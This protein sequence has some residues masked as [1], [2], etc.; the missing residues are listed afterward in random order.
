M[1]LP[2]IMNTCTK[3]HFFINLFNMMKSISH[4]NLFLIVILLPLHSFI[5]FVALPDDISKLQELTQKVGGPVSSMK[6]EQIILVAVAGSAMYNLNTP[7][8][9]IDYVV[10][11]STP[12]DVSE[13]FTS[14]SIDPL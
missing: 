6:P 10:V 14:L 1:Q 12:V 4:E 7:T 2:G 11:Y 9:D 13:C 8:S 3:R 5:V